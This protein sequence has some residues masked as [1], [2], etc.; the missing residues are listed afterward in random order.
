MDKQ[1]C[2]FDGVETRPGWLRSTSAAALHAI[3]QWAGT[4]RGDV[5]DFLERRGNRG[6]TIEEMARELGRKESTICGRLDELRKAG[7]VYRTDKTR[8]NSSG[9]A[10]IVWFHKRA[11]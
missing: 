5:R 4:V 9:F 6:A 3:E 2:L 10:A 11:V 7:F 8:R 1:L